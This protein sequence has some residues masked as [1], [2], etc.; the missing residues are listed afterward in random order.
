MKSVGEAKEMRQ[1]R[2]AVVVRDL[3]AQQFA[4]WSVNGPREPNLN[5]RRGAPFPKKDWLFF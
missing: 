3:D 2:L 5:A 4:A 1:E